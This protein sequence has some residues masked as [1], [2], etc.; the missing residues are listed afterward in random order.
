MSAGTM[1]ARRAVQRRLVMAAVLVALA[2]GLSLVVLAPQSPA[3]AASMASSSTAG[4]VKPVTAYAASAASDMATPI[5]TATNTSPRGKTCNSGTRCE[6]A[7]ASKAY[8]RGA[9]PKRKRGLFA[10][11]RSSQKHG[12][13]S[14]HRASDSTPSGTDLAPDGHAAAIAKQLICGTISANQTL[15]PSSALVYEVTCPTTIASGATLTVAAGSVVK[16]DAG[17]GFEVSGRLTSSGTAASPVYLTSIKDDSVGGDTNG[18]GR[19][20]RRAP[21]TGAGSRCRTTGTPLRR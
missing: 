8:A 10:R 19:A 9:T 12:R 5:T 14:R 6:Q 18:D 2:A 11:R 13:S 20:S 16:F 21:V 4:L 17:A 7:V 1:A 15:S 3:E